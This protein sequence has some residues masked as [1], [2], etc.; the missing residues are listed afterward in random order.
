MRY[1]CDFDVAAMRSRDQRRIEAPAGATAA[2]SAARQI[3]REC[4]LQLPRAVWKEYMD[5]AFSWD[6]CDPA[7]MEREMMDAGLLDPERKPRGS[8]ICGSLIGVALL[9][10]TRAMDAASGKIPADPWPPV[11][12]AARLCGI[13]FGIVV[14]SPTPTNTAEIE[15]AARSTLARAAQSARARN[16]PK[17]AAKAGALALW[18]E[19]REGKHPSLRTVEQFAI[20]VMRRWPVLQSSKVICGWSAKWT[21]QARDRKTPSC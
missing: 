12:S 20:E 21:K 13:A 19:R 11:A 2:F 14:G 10:C 18:I 4:L 8:V 6:A 5:M 15:A 7:E 16:D 1:R 3:A 9:Y 17:Q